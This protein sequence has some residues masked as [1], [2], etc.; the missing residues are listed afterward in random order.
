[1]IFAGPY[2]PNPAELLEE[3][4]FTRL[5]EYGRNEFDYIMI[6]TP[7]MANLIDGAIVARQCDG[8]V[9]VIESGAMSYR[10][11]QRVKSQLEK[12]GLRILGVV[13]NKVDIYSQS[14]YGKYGKYGTY[15]K[16]K[17]YGK[18]GKYGYDREYDHRND[19][20]RARQAQDFI[21]RMFLLVCLEKKRKNTVRKSIHEW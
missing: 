1:M 2:S 8:A 12:S 4:L 13:L 15:G 20:E 3:K 11:E 17:K 6:D 16:Y 10:I 9:L 5:L 19:E 18:Y 14:Y 21:K 7:P